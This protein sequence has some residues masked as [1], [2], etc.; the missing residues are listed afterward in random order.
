[1]LTH[2]LILSLTFKIFTLSSCAV[3]VFHSI[4]LSHSFLWSH[5]RPAD[6]NWVKKQHKQ[7]QQQQEQQ[8]QTNGKKSGWSLQL[9][10]IMIQDNKRWRRRRRQEIEVPS[11]EEKE[12]KREERK[13]V[14]VLS[15]RAGGIRLKRVNKIVPIL[16]CHCV[17]LLLFRSFYHP[18]IINFTSST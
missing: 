8:Q 5:S 7:Q 1:M 6:N 10:L 18:T 2:V 3:V 9:H 11:R 14:F 16:M 4:S 12:E 17:Y 15:E 13:C